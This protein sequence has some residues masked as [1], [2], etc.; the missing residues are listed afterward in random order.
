[1]FFVCNLLAADLEQQDIFI[2]GRDGYH[3][4][5][6]PSLIVTKNGTLL[7]FC[8]G[9]V[10]SVSDAGDIDIVLKR[11]TDGGKTW[12]EQVVV[13][14]DGPNTC[15]N[16]CPVVDQKTGTIWLSLT[17]NL[18]GDSEAE[19]NSKTARSTRTV[20]I[21]QS[22]ND[23][24]T[25]SAPVEI[26]SSVKESSW[27]WYATG[28]GVGIQIQHGPHKGRL[29]IPCDHSEGPSPTPA[30]TVSAS[31]VIYSDDHG[32]SWNIGGTARPGM[33]ECQVVELADGKGSMLLSMR[34]H[35]RGDHRAESISHDGGKTW[36][37]PVRN[38]QLIDPTCQASILRYNW[39]TKKGELG[40][41]LFS[42]PASNR[43]RNLTVRLSYDD[44]KT[45]PISNV[46]W[47]EDAAYSCLAVMKDGQIGCLYERGERNAYEKI[48]FAR[49]STAWLENK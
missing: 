33:N 15:G 3:S 11:S 14:N 22:K 42:N 38:S 48:T 5:R 8:E 27:G 6:I 10:N 19:I 39:P 43:R 44:G 18:G 7:A 35:P 32:K 25:W 41:I 20:W 24:K 31:H 21:S 40:R 1:M 4:Y 49:F 23:G 12:S 46:L 26:T 29:V 45:W 16:P 2:A 34:N 37:E 13:W 9:R 36:S 28:P 17:H 30:R 47:A